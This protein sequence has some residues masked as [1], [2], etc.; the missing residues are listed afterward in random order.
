MLGG[1]E[2]DHSVAM[3]WSHVVYSHVGWK[4]NVKEIST[5]PR[6]ICG[7]GPPLPVAFKYLYPGES[8]GVSY[9][10]CYTNILSVSVLWRIGLWHCTVSLSCSIICE[11]G[12]NVTM[13]VC[14]I[15]CEQGRNVT[16][17]E[18]CERTAYYVWHNGLL[19][20]R[21]DHLHPYGMPALPSLLFLWY[22]CT[23]LFIVLIFCF[24]IMC[25]TKVACFSFWICIKLFASLS[26]RLSFCLS[27]TFCCLL[28]AFLLHCLLCCFVEMIMKW[29]LDG[30][31]EYSHITGASVTGPSSCW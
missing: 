29:Y 23:A 14:S 1:W 22:A 18:S 10:R 6:L 9:T 30:V 7:R 21:T 2:G 8:S 16:T 3:C 20:H 24:D 15:M 5:P 28:M 25:N 4:V 31:G 12:R 17:E 19:W 27:L 11:Q 26:F 13:A